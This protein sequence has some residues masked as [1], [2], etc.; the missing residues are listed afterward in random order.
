M[1]MFPFISKHFLL[2]KWVYDVLQLEE[3]ELVFYRS[4]GQ[5]IIK[6][7]IHQGKAWNVWIGC[8]KM[9]LLF[10]EKWWCC[11][12]LLHWFRSM[13]L[14]VVM[15]P[16]YPILSIH[17]QLTKHAWTLNNYKIHMRSQ[18]GKKKEERKKDV[19]ASWCTHRRRFPKEGHLQHQLF[20]FSSY[21]SLLCHTSTFSTA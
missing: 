13:F 1:N 18:K 21:L 10:A 15:G 12:K 17:V 19:R 7:M 2:R 14:F 8:K 5:Y 11:M 9:V 20:S 4:I 6:Y 16:R 3:P